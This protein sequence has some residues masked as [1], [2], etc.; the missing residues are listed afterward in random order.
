MLTGYEVEAQ[1]QVIE[2]QMQLKYSLDFNYSHINISGRELYYLEF[3]YII[4]STNYVFNDL[5]YQN[6]R[7]GFNINLKILWCINTH[8]SCLDI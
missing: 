6:Q 1:C 7:F 8:G 2:K 4:E 5:Y 3:I